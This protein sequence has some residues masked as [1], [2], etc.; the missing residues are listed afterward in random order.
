MSKIRHALVFIVGSILFSQLITVTA[1]SN[2]GYTDDGNIPRFGT[3]DWIALQGID[4]LPESET[5][6]IHDNMDSFLLGTELPD[7]SGHPSGIGDT[8]LHHVYYDSSEVLVDDSAAVRAQ[9]EYD[10]A[11]VLFNHGHFEHAALH[12]GKMTHYISD[13]GVFGHVMGSGTDW[14][15]EVHHSDYENSADTRMDEY[16]VDG[17][18]DYIS[19]DGSLT[20]L[21]PYNG[22]I[23]VAYDTTFDV[24]G[25]Y[26]CTWMDTN[27]GFSNP[28]F[29]DRAGES[30]NL[31]VNTV[32]DVV[33]S[34]YEEASPEVTIPT[35]D[36][37]YTHNEVR[38]IHPSTES[39]KPLGCPSAMVTDWLASAYVHEKLESC[40]EGYDTDSLFV[41]QITGKPVGVPGTGIVTFGGPVVNPVVKYSE[42]P[43]TVAGDRAP[44]KYHG[45]SGNCIFREKDGS[46]IPGASL[47][48]SEVNTGKDMFVIELFQDVGGRNILIIYG[49]GWQ[50][51][52]AA[53]KYFDQIVYPDQE[54]Y[55]CHYIIGKWEDTNGDGFVNAPNDG[56]TYTLIAKIY[57][58]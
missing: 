18:T 39:G 53:G 6:W 10:A 16:P 57:P 11:M 3:H 24:D 28:L 58:S 21:T 55:I 1:W 17:F 4:L 35:F 27:Y 19:Y 44:V 47:P 29:E 26:T 54:S 56:D 12:L 40:S 14:G 45:E 43:G 20:T 48:V 2:G 30:V 52:Y 50:G 33:H 5:W 23:D 32:A 42:D 46:D 25:S 7:N 37:H 9:A 8:S 36:Y 13:L 49:F 34:F 15:S 41:D 22:A 31:C 51:T 38:M